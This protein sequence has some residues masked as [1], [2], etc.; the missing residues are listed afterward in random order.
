MPLP[1]IPVIS[2]LAAGGWLVPHAA[3]GLIV[4]SA[5]GYVAGTYLREPL[6]TRAFY[7]NRLKRQLPQ[8]EPSTLSRVAAS[9]KVL[10]GGRRRAIR[11]PAARLFGAR[12]PR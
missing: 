3:G 10:D 2:A 11:L 7:Q 4:T 1:L 5:S 12:W 6:N 8:G 9:R